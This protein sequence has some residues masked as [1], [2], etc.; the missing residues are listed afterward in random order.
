L[1]GTDGQARD[2]IW[3]GAY[4]EKVAADW[5]RSQGCK[6]LARNFRGPRRGEVDIIARDHK[7]LLFVEVKTRRAGSKIRGLDAVGKDKQGLIERGANAWLKRLGT[8]DLPWRFDVIEVNV[9]EG[10]KPKINHVRD[11]F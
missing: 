3:L 9:K 1:T 11:A 2:R 6:I 5:L 4:G 8:R 7:L 10:E